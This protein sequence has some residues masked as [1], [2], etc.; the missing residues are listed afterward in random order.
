MV[1]Y[2]VFNNLQ[3]LAGG[4]S[5]CYHACMIEWRRRRQFMV[6]LIIALP[7]IAIGFLFFPRLL[8]ESS[9]FDNRR[10]QGEFEVDCGGPCLPC[11]LKNPKNINLFWAKAAQAKTNVYDMVAYIENPNEIL[12]SP[13]LEYEFALFD[14]FGLIARR[15]GNTFILAEERLHIVEPALETK[16]IP[17]R[18]EFKVVDVQWEVSTKNP[19]NLVIERREYRVAG[20]NGKK[21]GVVE[22]SILNRS[23]FDLREVEVSFAVTDKDGNILGAN[24]VLLENLSS[25]TSKAIKSIWPEELKGEIALINVE[26]R[27]NVFNPVIIIK[28]R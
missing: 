18:V 10:N 7:F 24:R 14:E 9:C 13:R 12:V 19:L 8:P 11:E 4:D 23:L 27:V 26:P 17:V 1:V 21:Y 3:V 6:L 2:N 22:A 16:R 28:P 25:G 20:E 15:R 5:L